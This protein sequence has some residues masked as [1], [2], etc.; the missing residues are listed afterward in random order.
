MIAFSI[1]ESILFGIF[2]SITCDMS[3]VELGKRK[4]TYCC[5]NIEAKLDSVDVNLVMTAV[6]TTPITTS[7]MRHSAVRIVAIAVGVLM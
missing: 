1:V 6:A 2:R 3:V 4:E 7:T 5:T